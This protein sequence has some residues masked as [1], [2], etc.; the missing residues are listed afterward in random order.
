MTASIFERTLTSA[1]MV[2]LFADRALIEA[3]LAF[4][5][6]LDEAEA[7]EGVIPASAV[8]PIARA[9]REALDVEALVVEARD[10]GSLAIPLV[11]RLTAQVAAHAAGAA[12]FVHFGSTRQD[13]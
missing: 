12:S 3:M 5:A 7:A 13:V 11:K 2:E 1:T 10:A 6:A 4:E 9:C 8:E